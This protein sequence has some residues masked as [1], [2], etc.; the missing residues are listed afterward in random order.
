MSLRDEE[1]LDRRGRRARDVRL[2]ELERP[3]ERRRPVIPRRSSSAGPLVVK[4]RHGHGHGGDYER[5]PREWHEHEEVHVPYRPR[6][7]SPTVVETE[8]ERDQMYL[9]RP[10]SRPRRKTREIETEW[11]VEAEPRIARRTR[12]IPDESDEIIISRERENRERVTGVE[13]DEVIVRHRHDRSPSTSES[14]LDEPPPIRAPPIHQDVITHHRHVEHGK[15][16]R[17]M[18]RD[19]LTNSAFIGYVAPERPRRVPDV[20]EIEVRHR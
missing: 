16:A 10:R 18:N 9:R 12:A 3:C 6:R 2:E 14:S 7:R 5:I 17:L 13:R 11:E 15:S 1:R 20:D 4:S 8:R 19:S